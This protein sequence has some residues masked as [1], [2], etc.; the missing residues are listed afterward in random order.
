VHELNVNTDIESGQLAA[1]V[2]WCQRLLKHTQHFRSA[3]GPVILS[4][5]DAR[6]YAQR[7]SSL[8]RIDSRVRAALLAITSTVA[9]PPCALSA[10]NQ[11]EVLLVGTLEALKVSA[12]AH[13]A[14]AEVLQRQPA[15][16]VSSVES[17]AQVTAVVSKAAQKLDCASLVKDT[18][19]LDSLV[20][21]MSK[22][23]LV[24]RLNVQLVSGQD[25]FR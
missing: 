22:L 10:Y 9:P 13:A 7:A 6:Q 21:I 4:L 3:E 23:K 25:N 24:Q 16:F 18:D 19:S 20:N 15:E 17:N 5:T 11:C 1:I 14:V 8:L 2:S 12:D